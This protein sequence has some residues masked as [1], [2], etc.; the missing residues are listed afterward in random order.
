M[1]DNF[2][3]WLSWGDSVDGLLDRGVLLGNSLDDLLENSDLFDD[4]WSLF[5]WKSWK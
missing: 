3:D 1:E 4:S 2:W 5:L